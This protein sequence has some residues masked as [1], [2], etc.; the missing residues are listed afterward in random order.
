MNEKKDTA[1]IIREGLQEK[2]CE[3]HRVAYDSFKGLVP[4]G[5]AVGLADALVLRELLRL[6]VGH[7]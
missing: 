5:Q 2:M 4:E 6:V 3:V 7:F 1:E